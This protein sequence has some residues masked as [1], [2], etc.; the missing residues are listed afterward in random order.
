MRVLKLIPLLL[1]LFTI[2]SCSGSSADDETTAV[3]DAQSPA[4][5]NPPAYAPAPA[6]APA[7]A[8]PARTAAAPARPRIDE[9]ARPEP[10]ARPV[11]RTERVLIPAGTEITVALADPLNSGKNQPGDEFEAHLSDPIQSS[12]G[13]VLVDR[14]SKVIGKVADVE[15]SGRVKGLANM[16]LVLV[17]L[18]HN[19][20]TTPIT[21]KS[22][23]VEAQA[24]KGR[25]AAVVGGGAGIGAAIGAITGGKKGAATGAAI[26]GAA[27]AGTVLATKGKEVDF[28]PESKITFVLADDLTVSR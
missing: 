27:G 19:G 17:S 12:T 9:T 14:G 2:S 7:P 15:D 21:T 28:P 22:F 16:R 4:V 18:T 6:P 26:G 5:A 1:V 11:D 13:A 20:R 25:D 8:R 23:F 24:S 10:P 3:N